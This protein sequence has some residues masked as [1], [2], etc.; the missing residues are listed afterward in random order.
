MDEEY[1][2]LLLQLKRTITYLK[3]LPVTIFVIDNSEADDIISYVTTELC[4]EE[5][6]IS[7]TDKDFYQLINDKIKVW[8]PVKKCI[9]DKEA[10]IKRFDGI[11]INNLLLSRSICGDKSDNIKGI[12][13]FGTKTLIKYFPFLS[14]EKIY[15]IEDLLLYCDNNNNKN[16]KKYQL[17]KDNIE[18]IKINAKVTEMGN[19]NI[20]N[21]SKLKIIDEFNN[22]PYKTDF[23]NIKKLY[24]HDKLYVSIKN[25][26]LWLREN[27]SYLDSFCKIKI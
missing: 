22:I 15:T 26:D 6:I 1:K 14:E 27:F 11:H 5:V 3:F 17:I 20:S 9:I 25:I 19:R 24:A 23:F 12:S 18:K 8:N 13:G 4:K 10:A 2:N 7:S 16:Y 21:S